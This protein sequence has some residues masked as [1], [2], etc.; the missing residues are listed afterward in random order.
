M[1]NHEIARRFAR[2]ADTLEIQG[3]NP[4]KVRAYRRAVEVIEGL[5]EPLTEIESR[6]ELADIA[7][8]GEAIVAK[9][10][11]FLKTG[12]TKLYEQIKD[13]VPP[14]VLAIA[15]V[16]GIGPKTARA[17]WESLHVTTVEEL[18]AAA[19][20]GRVQTAPGF[21]AA[22]E[23]N[24]LEAIERG[25]R[26][27]E[28]LPLYVA[29]PYAERLAGELARRPEVVRADA[30]GSVRRHRDTVGDLDLVAA[31]TDP[32][33]TAAAVAGLSGVTEVF[34]SGPAKVAAMTDLGLRLDVRLSKPEDYGALLHH[35]SSGRQHNIELRDLAESQGLKINEYGVF[36]ARTGME[37][38]RGEDEVQVYAALGLPF[39]E[40]ELREGKGE[41]EAAR[42]GAL[43]RLVSD[44]DFRGQ[45]HEHTTWSDGTATV[46]EMAE[47]AMGRGY[48]YLAI[49]DHS[50]SLQ[51]ANG[52]SRERL[53]E[54]LEEIAGLKREFASRGFAL[55]A[56]IEADILADG[57]LDADDDL[58]ARL[59]IVVG[60]VHVRHR[61]DEAAM[62]ARILRAMENPFLQILGHPTG[63]LLGRRE[64]FAVDMTAVID[65]AVR[66]G[67]I[68]EIN[69]SPD[70]M[71]LSDLYARQA[72]DKG[73]CLTINADA[74]SPAG[75]GALSWGLYM[76]RRA[77]L[78]PEDVV[79]TY[80]L[81]ELRRLLKARPA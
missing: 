13:A 22:K 54:Q 23:K 52:L 44:A 41:I 9:T 61:E 18:E 1:T 64:P 27:S 69:A 14:G 40:P 47:A 16:P 70:R 39:I 32:D 4:F 42:R 29:A 30:A 72:K 80:P 71:D 51:I 36:D 49:T 6:G 73:A 11:D 74:H 77:W 59:D 75:L 62:T 31:T 60:S 58:L 3:E 5:S 81:A 37:K 55:L 20:A 48:E 35:F 24:I 38:F 8:F 25:R 43:P 2:I 53:L 19:R 65:A 79:N 34:E 15:A 7:G 28:R 46:R 66:T 50:R 10:R 26:L 68:L 57:S 56:G 33:A 78:T 12:T 17:L 67:T 63:R 76:A 21:G 45:L